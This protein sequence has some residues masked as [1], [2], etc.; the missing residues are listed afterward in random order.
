[1]VGRGQ[2]EDAMGDETPA[3][4][5][6]IWHEGPDGMAVWTFR[7]D[8]FDGQRLPAACL[9]TLTVKRER[10]RGPRGR[11]PGP[12]EQRAW[13][14]ELRLEPAVVVERDRSEKRDGAVER[15]RELA[16]AFSADDLDYPAAYQRPRE[17]YLALLDELLPAA[18]E[19]ARGFS[20]RAENRPQ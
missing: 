2:A 10:H 1:M 15:A 20:G 14:V 7:P 6:T 5:W 4:G 18:S 3:P 8:V 17:D 9:P 16:A 19:E 12:D 11:P 13:T